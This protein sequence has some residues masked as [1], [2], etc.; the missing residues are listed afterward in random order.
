M[1]I[2]NNL[3]ATETNEP[4]IELDK[5]TTTAFDVDLNTIANTVGATVAGAAAAK[6]FGDENLILFS[7]VFTLSILIFSEIL[8]KNKE[9]TNRIA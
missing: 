8:P 5:S 9:L 7:T 4:T 3:V 6:L 2:L 1:K